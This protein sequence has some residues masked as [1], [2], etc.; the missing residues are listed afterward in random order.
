MRRVKNPLRLC[1]NA[2]NDNSARAV[3]IDF[4]ADC[5]VT[6]VELE[7]VET[8]LSAII[9]ALAAGPEFSADNDNAPGGAE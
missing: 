2:A 3:R 7:I 4:P 1:L 9:Q 8:Y 5:P 6:D